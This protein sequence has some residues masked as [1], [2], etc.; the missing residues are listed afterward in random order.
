MVP[1]MMRVETVGSAPMRS[2]GPPPER[3]CT[4][5]SSVISEPAPFSLIFFDPFRRARRY[6]FDRRA[7]K[8]LLQVPGNH[9]IAFRNTG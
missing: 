6:R 5:W 7:G 9:L 3:S 1:G 2:D 8:D 4:L